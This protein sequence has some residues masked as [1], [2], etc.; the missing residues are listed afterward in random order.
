MTGNNGF[1]TQTDKDFLKADGEYYTGEHAKQSRYQR[2]E[3][4]AERAR[5]AFRDFA[6]LFETL[7]EA[8]RNRVFD[9]EFEDVPRLGDDVRDT[10]AFLYWATE[11]EPGLSGPERSFTLTFDMLF[12][13]AIRRAEQR[14]HDDTVMMHYEPYNIEPVRA[15]ASWTKVAEELAETGGTGVSDKELRAAIKQLAMRTTGDTSPSPNTI[16]GEKIED[17]LEIGDLYDLA[18]F[19]EKKAQGE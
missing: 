12:E 6:F 4:I 7:D 8:E 18:E 17:Q 15:G 19:V 3:A 9:P 11:A 1:L 10:L 5:E 16:D 13:P 2:R 14:R